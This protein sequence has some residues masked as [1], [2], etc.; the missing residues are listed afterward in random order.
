V[1]NI[2]SIMVVE[3]NNMME[4]EENFKGLPKCYVKMNI[5]QVIE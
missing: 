5:G 1:A 4:A 2:L 3:K